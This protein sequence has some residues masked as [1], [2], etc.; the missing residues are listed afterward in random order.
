[1][2]KKKIQRLKRLLREQERALKEVTSRLDTVARFYGC[3]QFLNSSDDSLVPFPA[4]SLLGRI[5]ADNPSRR[6]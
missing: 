1:M 2:A 3:R 6:S 4:K 5:S